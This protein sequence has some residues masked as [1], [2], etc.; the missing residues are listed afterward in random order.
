MLMPEYVISFSNVMVA[1]PSGM[2][3]ESILTRLT[4]AMFFA[5]DSRAKGRLMLSGRL[6][7]MTRF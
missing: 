5:S 7:A 3:P 6:W 2:C 1:V 4:T